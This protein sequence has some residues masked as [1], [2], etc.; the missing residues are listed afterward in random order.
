[1]GLVYNNGDEQFHIQVKPGEVVSVSEA[2]T[3]DDAPAMYREL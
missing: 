1:M 2:A 3:K